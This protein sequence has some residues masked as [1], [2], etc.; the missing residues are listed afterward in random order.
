VFLCG[1]G[2]VGI[3]WGQS[4]PRAPTSSKDFEFR[5]ASPSRS[6]WASRRSTSTASQN[7]IVTCFFAAAADS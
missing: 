5:P 1:A 6:C 7:G 3:A 2:A 4:R